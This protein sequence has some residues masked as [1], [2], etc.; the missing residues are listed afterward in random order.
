EVLRQLIGGPAH[1][2]AH[3]CVGRI[4]LGLRDFDAPAFALT[5]FELFLDKLLDDL[6]AIGS[7]L[8]RYLNELDSLVDV[9]R[10]DR[11]AIDQGHNA[12]GDRGSRY[13]RE[14]QNCRDDTAATAKWAEKV[15]G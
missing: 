13:C 15:N 14:E 2:P 5:D 1:A 7:L 9:E 8:G 6:L 11:F 3:V 10:G 4:N 12:L